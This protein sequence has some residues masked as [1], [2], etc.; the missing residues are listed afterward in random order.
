MFRELGKTDDSWVDA[1]VAALSGA[2][3]R[4]SPDLAA[5]VV[6][7]SAAGRLAACG[8]G[9]LDRRLPGPGGRSGIHGHIGSMYTEVQDR[10]RGHGR[11]ILGALL[12]WFWESEAERVQLWASDFSAP[13]FAAEGFYIGNPLWQLRR[14]PSCAEASAAAPPRSAEQRPE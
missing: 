9:Y 8:V 6:E 10:R 11:A 14:P 13:L 2:L 3:G 7:G 4:E 1:C 12:D 5:F